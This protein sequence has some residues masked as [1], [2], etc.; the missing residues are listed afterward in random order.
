MTT[1]DHGTSDL[2]SVCEV[3]AQ[4][5]AASR[6]RLAKL[7]ERKNEIDSTRQVEREAAVERIRVRDACSRTQAEARTRSDDRYAD[8]VRTDGAV[9]V[10]VLRAETDAELARM[11]FD[12]TLQ[13]LRLQPAEETL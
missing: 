4:R 3:Q 7:T 1:P 10:E 2:A 9:T 6:E 13:L 11:R 12:L 8:F 5:Y